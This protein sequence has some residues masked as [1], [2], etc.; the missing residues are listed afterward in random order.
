MWVSVNDLAINKKRNMVT[1]AIMTKLQYHRVSVG[2]VIRF[3]KVVVRIKEINNSNEISRYHSHLEESKFRDQEDEEAPPIGIEDSKVIEN[4][5]IA[6][7]TLIDEEN[8]GDMTGRTFSSR[9]DTIM[10]IG[11]RPNPSMLAEGEEPTCRIC[12]SEEQDKDNP[13]ISPCK[14]DGTMKYIHVNCLKEWLL[15]SRQQSKA[16]FCTTYKWNKLGCELCKTDLPGNAAL[17]NPARVLI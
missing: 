16:R 10:D 1:P 5:F 11:E 9:A 13:M 14:C 12:L 17:E 6:P 3:G 2:D 8:K 15:S 7:N 4:E